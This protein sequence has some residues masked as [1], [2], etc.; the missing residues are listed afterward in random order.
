MAGSN[1]LDELKP[2]KRKVQ[3]R[4]LIKYLNFLSDWRTDVHHRTVN[5]ESNMLLILRTE[6]VWYVSHHRP[7]GY[8]SGA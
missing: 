3:R 6:V 5:L 8:M 4:I 1:E 7:E 2:K